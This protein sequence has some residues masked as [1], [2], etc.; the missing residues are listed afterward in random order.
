MAY[1]IPTGNFGNRQAGPMQTA[2]IPAGGQQALGRAVEGLENTADAIVGDMQAQELHALK[3]QR[4]Q[5]LQAKIAADHAQAQVATNAGHDKLADL[6]DEIAQ[7]VIDGTVEKDKAEATYND[8]AAGVLSD[9]SEAMPQ[10]YR[11]MGEAALQA[12][13]DRMGNQVRRAVTQRDRMDV[14]AGLSQT[15]EFLQRE[16]QKDPADATRRAMDNIDQLG[17]HSTLSP[18]KLQALKQGWKEG[19]QYTAGYEA[20]SAGRNDP[21]ALA[22]GEK[23]VTDGLPDLDPQK[24]AG[25][26]DRAQNYRLA[27]EQRADMLRRRALAE[28]DH[29]LRVAGAAYDLGAKLAVEGTLNPEF[30]EQQL[31]NMAGTPYQGAFK[32]LLET[33]RQNG[34]L[35]AQP[36]AVLQQAIDQVNHQITVGGIT[37]ELAAQRDRLTKVRDGQN[38]DIANMG[39][40]RAAA[41]R[42][43]IDP[44]PP[45]DFSHGPA[46]V[47]E[48]IKA[49]AKLVDKVSAWSGKQ[50]SPVYPDEALMLHS[51]LQALAP[52]DRAGYVAMLA[53]AMGPGQAQAF[54][55]QMDKHDRGLGLAFASAADMTTQGR[56]TSEL[57]LAGQQAK[58]DGTSTKREKVPGENE[59][60]WRANAANNI[61]DAYA[62][63]EM[64]NRV[65]DAAVLIAHA[66][67]AEGNGVP[68]MEEAT[69]LA[70]GGTIVEHNG[71]KV[72]LP[73]GVTEAA[74][75]RRLATV[76]SEEIGRQ[77]PGGAVRAAGVDIPIEDF[78][79]S[80]PGQQLVPVEKQGRAVR[81]QY[82][83]LVNG[84]PV[85]NA[86]GDPIQIGVN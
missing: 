17:P 83:V 33:Q 43:V 2:T 75:T 18:E 6:H 3:E 14:T 63:E 74:L 48:Q 34:P 5:E 49:R 47:A 37:T 56:Y 46:G 62:N 38:T 73:A 42:T 68:D 66:K 50:E 28:E 36:P 25:L 86:A 26:L 29:R 81:G 21:K 16:Y 55:Q 10:A 19:T 60:R 82:F 1:N 57:I 9:A 54:A 80:L 31:K 20:I 11:P 71:R 22:R 70:V 76:T 24:R 13:R 53:G 61:G 39:G 85:V 4:R 78:V 41:K 8:R 7:G 15:L 27:H 51:Q 65:L 59:G 77:A 32:Q 58:K 45:L 23:L 44:P 69:H 12:K 30:A 79:K 84:R 40:L 64:R 67:A 52:K 35:A 72:P